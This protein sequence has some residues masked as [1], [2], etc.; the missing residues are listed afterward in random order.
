MR[1]LSQCGPSRAGE[2]LEQIETALQGLAEVGTSGQ[3]GPPPWLML[4]TLCRPQEAASQRDVRNQRHIELD[5]RIWKAEQH[6]L[7]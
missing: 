5:Q 1:Y 7:G 6:A 4:K 2:S 3:K